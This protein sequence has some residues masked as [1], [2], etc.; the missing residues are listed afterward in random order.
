MTIRKISQKERERWAEILKWSEP[1]KG[2]GPL[3]IWE[4]RRGTR[5][6]VVFISKG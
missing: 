2:K 1:A 5:M 6:R 4:R 3:H